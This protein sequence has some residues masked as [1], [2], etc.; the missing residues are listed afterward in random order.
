MAQ[1]IRNP[2]LQQFLIIIDSSSAEKG[3]NW[4]VTAAEIIVSPR[5]TLLPSPELSPFPGIIVEEHCR[6]SRPS[7]SPWFQL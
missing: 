4:P 5:P 2:A 7:H 1:F 6:I 3:L